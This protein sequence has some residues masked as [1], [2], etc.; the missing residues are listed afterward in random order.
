LPDPVRGEKAATGVTDSTG[1][2]AVDV[3]AGSC[4]INVSE[5]GFATTNIPASPLRRPGVL[6]GEVVP[7]GYNN[8]FRRTHRNVVQMFKKLFR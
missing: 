1:L 3:P 4:S 6:V 2:Y 5:A 7:I 8:P